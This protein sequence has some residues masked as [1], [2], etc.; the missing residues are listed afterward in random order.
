MT[1]PRRKAGHSE[2]TKKSATRKKRKP[3]IG[4]SKIEI[5]DGTQE[6]PGRGIE[7]ASALG[8][9][10]IVELKRRHAPIRPSN[11]CS[12]SFSDATMPGK[13]L[14]SSDTRGK[15]NRI[16]KAIIRVTPATSSSASTG[17]G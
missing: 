16:T 13:P 10:P 12:F 6:I 3:V 1:K 4:G 7:T 11:T 17:R 2:I 9:S 14:A 8:G 15:I 5:V